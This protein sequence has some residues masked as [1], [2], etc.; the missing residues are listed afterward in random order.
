MSQISVVIVNWNTR[1]L[2][3][4][5]LAAV[6]DTSR[7][8]KIEVWV[9]D[10]ASTD[11]SA[12]MVRTRFPAAKLL[13]NS[14]NAGFGR[15]N[16]QVLRQVSTDY[17]LLLN[18]DAIIQPGALPAMWTWMEAHPAVGVVGPTL[19]NP[20]GSFQAAGN[21]FPRLLTQWLVIAGLAH[22]LLGPHFPSHGPRPDSEPVRTD[23]VGGACLLVRSRAIQAV[24][25]LDEDFFMY[26]E[27]TDWCYRMWQASWEVYWL[28]AAH[29]L[30]WRGQSSRQALALTPARLA[31]ASY[32]FFR[33]H[34]GQPRT[35]LLQ[36]GMVI[37]GLAKAAAFAAAYLA[38]GARCRSWKAK[39]TANWRIALGGLAPNGLIAHH[40]A[41]G[42]G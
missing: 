12:E 5:C 41:V 38:S 36:L 26:A 31:Q 40:G 29:C 11:G 9:V 19:L 30:H 1:E 14:G 37:L 18:P 34:Y 17:V 23:W 21:D 27:E 2:L 35:A 32:L 7:P 10:N 22:R 25:L 28:P 4:Q 15:A 24:G 3:E 16:N 33:K 39:V 13:Q 6:Y 8:P 42:P 20:D